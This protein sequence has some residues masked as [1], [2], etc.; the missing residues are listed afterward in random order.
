MRGNTIDARALKE[1]GLI[2]HSDDPVKI[3]GRGE[4]KKVITVKKI[5]VSKSARAKIEAAGGKI[6][7]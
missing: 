5:P 2:K 3:L 4:L 6:E 1:A 7:S